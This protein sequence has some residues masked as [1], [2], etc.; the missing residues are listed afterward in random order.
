MQ[1]KGRASYK[2]G[3]NISYKTGTYLMKQ[4]KRVYKARKE[5]L[6]KKGRNLIQNW[7]ISHTK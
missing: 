3:E 4:G 2:S 6:T 5:S 7:E 1:S